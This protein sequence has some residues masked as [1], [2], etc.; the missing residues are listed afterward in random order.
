MYA[1][2]KTDSKS[3]RYVKELYSRSVKYERDVSDSITKT[4]AERSSVLIGFVVVVLLL[5]F[6]HNIIGM[7][8]V[9]EEN[10]FVRSLAGHVTTTNV[11]F[12]VTI[13]GTG[14]NH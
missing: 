4:L 7:N 6:L 5:C 1:V 2:A 14:T 12:T 9:K 13:T 3:S 8:V 10:P 11:A